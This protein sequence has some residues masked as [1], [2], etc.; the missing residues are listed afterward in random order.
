MRRMVMVAVA[1]LGV[2]MVCVSGIEAHSPAWKGGTGLFTIYSAETLKAGEWGGSFYFNNFDREI[3]LGDTDPGMDLDLSYLSLPFAFG[4]TD[5]FEVF[6][7]ANYVYLNTDESGA[8]GSWAGMSFQDEISE[9]GFGDIDVGL[10]YRLLD[11]GAAPALA[12][13]ATVK[14]PTAD[15]AKG[16]GTGETDYGLKLLASKGFGS[17]AAHLNLGYTVIGEPDG[18]DWDD[19][20]SYGLGVLIPRN[21]N[22]QFIGELAGE[23]DY[24]PVRDES[25][26]DLTLGARYHFSSGLL[27][28]AG[29]RYGL[30]MDF[31]DCPLGGV[32]QIGYHTA[33]T[34]VPVPTATPVPNSPP[35]VSCDSDTLVVV[36]GNYTR[37]TAK[38]T[39]PDGDSLTYRWSATGCRLEVAGNEAK[40][41]T[42]DCAP[43]VYTVS[44]TVMD[45]R[46]GE[47]ACSV[48][49]TVERAKPELRKLDLPDVPFRKGC[50]V[51]NVA[52]AVLD[53][54]AL[55]IKRYPNAKV[56]LIGH[57]DSTGSEQ[58]NLRM[59][60]CRARAARDYLVQRHG[61]DPNR[62]VIKSEGESKPKFD[63]D[64]AEGRRK[65]R[66]VEVVMWVKGP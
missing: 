18:A 59:G 63:N 2:A 45:G 34:P 4:V 1:T 51:D 48:D 55:Q 39:D 23:T 7:A 50:R 62:F 6:A 16:L 40:L 53:D 8:T 30:A 3:S 31:D 26:L 60:E 52:K 42:D 65:N 66:R 20:I 64:T 13:M 28:G 25:T 44:C 61:F 14:M 46:G 24:D 47:A 37:I 10:K 5:R 19:V 12:V 36:Q 21:K 57:T 29:L 15:E 41:F 56:T 38:A 58:A 17:V 49:I 54:I 32:V 27:L 33:P 9:S 43:G 22:L 35:S 11:E